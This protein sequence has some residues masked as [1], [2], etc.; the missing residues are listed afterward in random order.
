MFVGNPPKS[1]R[2][3]P[4]LYVHCCTSVDLSRKHTPARPSS[5]STT[6][7]HRATRGVVDALTGLKT[8]KEIMVES[9]PSFRVA[10]LGRNSN[11]KGRFL[12]A[13]S[14]KP[15]SDTTLDA[16]AWWTSTF[17]PKEADLAQAPEYGFSPAG[18]RL[19]SARLSHVSA[20]DIFKSERNNSGDECCCEPILLVVPAEV[21]FHKGQPRPS[22]G[23]VNPIKA[24]V[25]RTRER[26][27]G[28]QVLFAVALSVDFEDEGC[29]D[30]IVPTAAVKAFIGSMKD[31]MDLEGVPLVAVTPRTELWLREQE[32]EGGRVSYR[33][34]DSSFRVSCHSELTHVSA[35]D[36]LS[37]E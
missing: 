25:A 37:G 7:R 34:G 27:G 23:G 31:E 15:L 9:S 32:S 35:F 5:D 2:K 4:C 19:L 6:P 24:I 29:V 16:E 11:C 14:T 26:L 18:E 21:A 12:K 20:S 36:A 30:S 8:H 1:H 33:R 17:T 10:L 13:A 22:R 3:T 28:G